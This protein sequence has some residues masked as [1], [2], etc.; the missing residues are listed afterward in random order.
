M[1][2]SPFR[3]QAGTGDELKDLRVHMA[4]EAEVTV[5][6]CAQQ[7]FLLNLVDHV[8]LNSSRDIHLP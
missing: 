4:R 1:Y 7:G 8:W 2:E 5:H 3:P 6:E